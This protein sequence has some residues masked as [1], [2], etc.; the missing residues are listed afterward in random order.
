[1]N[2]SI[3]NVPYWAFSHHHWFENY[4]WKIFKINIFNSE[5]YYFNSLKHNLNLIFEF[6]I[7]KFNSKILFDLKFDI[8]I[9][10]YYFRF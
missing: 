5:N 3:T 6:E 10:N 4:Q 7:K 1:M 9:L 8:W 2:F